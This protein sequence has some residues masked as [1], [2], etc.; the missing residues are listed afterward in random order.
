MEGAVLVDAFCDAVYGGGTV[1]GLDGFI[2][3]KVVLF[4]EGGEEGLPVVIGE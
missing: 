1:V 2:V 4:P 3:E